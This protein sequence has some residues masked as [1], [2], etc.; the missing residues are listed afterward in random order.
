MQ[1]LKKIFGALLIIIGL[2]SFIDLFI[3]DRPPGNVFVRL[4]WPIFPVVMILLGI[5]FFRK[6]RVDTILNV[7]YADVSRRGFALFVDSLLFL[8]PYIV[9]QRLL[10]KGPFL[11]YYVFTISLPFLFQVICIYFLVRYGATPGKIVAGI[12]LVKTDLE[13]IT[14]KEAFLRTVVDVAFG[15]SG[16]VA[17]STVLLEISYEEFR[18]LSYFE[19]STYFFNSFPRWYLICLSMHQYWFWG[20]LLVLMFNKKRR[21]IHDYI[22]GTVVVVRSTLGQSD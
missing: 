7:M 6:K 13:Q 4:T 21:A 20:E 8:I 10:L 3:G 18:M 9:L 19:G 5:G 11:T 14:I 22:A 17:M 12:K 2:F 16:F 15:F 1:I